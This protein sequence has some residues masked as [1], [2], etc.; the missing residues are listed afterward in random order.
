MSTEIAGSISYPR[1]IYS[2]EFISIA[3]ALRSCSRRTIM[4]RWLSTVSGFNVSETEIDVGRN[5]IDEN[6][7]EINFHTTVPNGSSNMCMP[8]FR[9]KLNRTNK[10]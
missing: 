5:V 10:F 4:A 2:G 8:A 3:S 7:R 6:C 9:N 1:S